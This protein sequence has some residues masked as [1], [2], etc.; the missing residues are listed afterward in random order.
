LVERNATVELAAQYRQLMID[1]NT[2]PHHNTVIV[3]S[4]EEIIGS[5]DILMVVYG[6][7]LIGGIRLQEQDGPE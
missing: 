2:N 1:N 7:L 6:G 5:Q 4:I 3:K